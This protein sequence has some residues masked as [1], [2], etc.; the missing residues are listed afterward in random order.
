MHFFLPAAYLIGA[1]IAMV[2][3]VSPRVMSRRSLNAYQASYPLISTIEKMFHRRMTAVLG[4]S[5]NVVRQLRDEGVPDEK[6][7]LIYNGLDSERFS[8]VS[9]EDARAVLNIAS[10]ELVLISIANLIPYKGHLDILAALAKA[11]S[12]LPSGW[13][14]LMVGRDDGIG[15]EL[16]KRANEYGLEAHIDFL[17]PRSDVPDLLAASDIG[18]LCSH[19]EGF[20]NSLLEGMA[21]G[22]AMVATD[23]GGN[24]EAIRHLESGI[25]VPPRDIARLAEVLERLAQDAPLRNQLGAAA[26]ARVVRHFSLERCVESYDALYR[27]L[28][29]GKQPVELSQVK[30]RQEL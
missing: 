16:R 5:I 3:G 2:A 6:L 19:E 4:N 14:M 8:L 9:R 10:D 27:G 28:I 12:K 22:L 18:L 23:V 24:A 29:A 15:P 20:S 21:A 13:R 30:V 17:G 1:P 25:I 26:R 7:G 11:K